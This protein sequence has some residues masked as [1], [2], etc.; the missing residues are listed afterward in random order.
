MFLPA[1]EK[2]DLNLASIKIDESA[3]VPKDCAGLVF[4]KVAGKN[5]YV[6]ASQLASA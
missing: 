1:G 5:L 4:K 3:E 2:H 6:A